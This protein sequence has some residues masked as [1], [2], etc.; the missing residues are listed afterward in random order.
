[1]VTIFCGDFVCSFLYKS[2]AVRTL[3]VFCE[4]QRSSNFSQSE[5][6][7]CVPN[8]PFTAFKMKRSLSH[9]TIRNPHNPFHPVTFTM[10]LPTNQ[11]AKAALEASLAMQAEL[12]PIYDADLFTPELVRGLA[13]LI[14]QNED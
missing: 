7:G 4:V 2:G 10:V 12:P 5:L 6:A 14:C 13:C 11:Q 3:F 9:K 1:M 8:H